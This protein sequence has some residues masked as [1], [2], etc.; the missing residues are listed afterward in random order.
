MKLTGTVQVALSFV[1]DGPPQVLPP[2]LELRAL[3]LSRLYCAVYPPSMGSA[4]PVT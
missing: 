2:D 1:V 3:A 4:T